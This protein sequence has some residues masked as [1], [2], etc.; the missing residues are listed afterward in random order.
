MLAAQ[1]VLGIVTALMAARL[2]VAIT[3]QIGAVIVFV[4]VLRAR[5]LVLY[6]LKGS[7]RKG[8]A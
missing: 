2:E 7:I 1:V 5:H 6:P 4:L 3:H 8:T